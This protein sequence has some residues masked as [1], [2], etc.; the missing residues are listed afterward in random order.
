MSLKPYLYS[1]S[2]TTPVSFGAITRAT[3]LRILWEI[4]G[5]VQ[6]I[7]FTFG[8]NAT[9]AY[10]FYKQYLGYRVCAF[11][12]FYD[13]PIAEGWI[14]GVALSK[15]GCSV[16]CK[17]PWFRHFDKFDDTDYQLA[18]TSSAIIKSSLTNFVP[19]IS[20]NQSHIAETSFTLAASG[21]W[22]LSEYGLYPGDLIQKLASMS[23][24]N[25][26]QW[27]YWIES[28]PLANMLPQL[29]VAYFEEQVDDGT[30]NW[31]VTKKDMTGDSM[32]QER[33]IEELANRVLVIY[34]DI[35]GGE[36]AL[37]AWA[38]DTASQASFWI[39][40]VVLTGGEMVPTGATQYRDLMLS[41]YK[42]PMLKNSFTIGAR[43]IRDNNGSRWPLWYPI[44][45]GGGYLRINDLYPDAITFDKSVDRERVGQIMSLEY[46]DTAHTLRVSLDTTDESADYLLSQ[47]SAFL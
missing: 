15:T 10:Q 26:K 41:K 36:Q 6:A 46:D 12:H 8:H 19:V 37:T 5:G 32:S 38:T 27:N 45:N 13:S 1:A 40:D 42:D 21:S 47:M 9:E 30:F 34:R 4:P 11:D 43:G 7:E 25:Y 44:K 33:N 29:P 24:N 18:Q 28:Q 39:R 17:G 16:L 14:Y 31:Q 2:L 35:A 20:S 23:N 3:N 22:S